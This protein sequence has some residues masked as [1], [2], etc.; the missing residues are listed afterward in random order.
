MDVFTRFED[1][2]IEQ[3]RRAVIA[4]RD[5]FDVGDV[6][7]AKELLHHLPPSVTYDS[8]LKNVQRLRSGERMRGAPFLNACIRFLEVKLAP[9]SPQAPSEQELALAMSRF[10]APLISSTDFQ[11]ELQGDYALQVLRESRIAPPAVP[12][13]AGRQP[14]G[15]PIRPI[16]EQGPVRM[17]SILSIIPRGSAGYVAVRERCFLAEDDEASGAPKLS[18]ANMLERRGICLPIGA[19]DV[20]L[21]I[22]DFM[23]SHMYVLRTDPAGFI[24]TMILPDPLGIAGMGMP[25]SA[26]PTRYDVALQKLRSR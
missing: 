10:V 3:I 20:L 9:S 19:H 22:R 8:V 18:E 14:R 1:H 12:G 26:P 5:R 6:T 4:Y 11:R 24:G 15:V 2:Q 7:L 17:L 16:R 25:A 13:H 23:F 21:M